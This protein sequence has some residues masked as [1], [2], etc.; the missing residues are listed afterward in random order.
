V[1]K[2]VEEINDTMQLIGN[3]LHLAEH[4]AGRDGIAVFGP[5]D[6]EIHRGVFLGI[7]KG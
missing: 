1:H 6:L 2:D 7:F 4:R 3:Y 5:G